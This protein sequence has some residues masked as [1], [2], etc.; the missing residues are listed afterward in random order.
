MKSAQSPLERGGRK[1]LCGGRGA[2]LELKRERC[3]R[4][5]YRE[6]Q[7]DILRLGWGGPV[8]AR[9]GAHSVTRNTN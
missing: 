6:M 1:G 5:R 4:T 7:R 2:V 8:W 3:P 9:Q